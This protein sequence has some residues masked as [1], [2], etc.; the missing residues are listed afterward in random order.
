MLNNLKV[1]YVRSNDLVKTLS[2]FD[3]LLIL[4]PASAED[5][6]DRGV[7]YSRLECFGQA[8]ADFESYL[9][10]APDADDAG[11]VRERLVEVAKQTVRI[12]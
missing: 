11:A 3:R 12:H 4:T 2:V 5:L 9:R 7:V 10:L 1:I 6:R 8:K